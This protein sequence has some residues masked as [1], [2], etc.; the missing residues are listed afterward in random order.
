MSHC[1]R[2]T[3]GKKGK[4][5]CKYNKNNVEPLGNRRIHVVCLEENFESGDLTS[6]P[7]SA[8]G[9]EASGSLSDWSW[10]GIS[11][12]WVWLDISLGWV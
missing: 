9:R 3:R 1:G 8:F 11:S 7:S 5:S 6:G 10:V 4:Q 12:G 2:K